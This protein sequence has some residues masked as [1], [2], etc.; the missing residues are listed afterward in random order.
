MCVACTPVLIHRKVDD[1]TSFDKTWD[2]F[3]AGFGDSSSGDFW[4]GNDRLHQLT[5]TEGYSKLIVQLWSE[6][7]GVI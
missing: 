7:G 6:S 4:I 2:E 1:S 3:Q 5:M